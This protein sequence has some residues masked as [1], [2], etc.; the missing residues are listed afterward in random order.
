MVERLENFL[1]DYA[2]PGFRMGLDALSPIES[3]PKMLA[4]RGVGAHD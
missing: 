2:T 1:A 4:Q 3:S